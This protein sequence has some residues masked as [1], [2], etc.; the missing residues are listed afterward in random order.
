M[1]QGRKNAEKVRQYS[2]EPSVEAFC[3]EEGVRDNRKTRRE[4]RCV[5]AC[6][7]CSEL[8]S[9]CGSA[10][11]KQFCFAETHNVIITYDNNCGSANRQ[12][13]NQVEGTEHTM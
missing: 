5:R 1:S 12:Q 7:K 3:T 9:F 2:L 11:S 6:V 4:D 8:M 10:A 13:S